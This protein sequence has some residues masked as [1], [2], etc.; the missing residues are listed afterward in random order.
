MRVVAGGE[1][2]DDTLPNRY[3]GLSSTKLTKLT[4]VWGATEGVEGPVWSVAL[5]SDGKLAVVSAPVGLEYED[6]S[7]ESKHL[8]QWMFT[9]HDVAKGKV[10]RAFSGHSSY[11]FAV[12]FSPDGKQILSG[13]EDGT[14]RLW[15]ISTGKELRT[16]EGHKGRVTGVAFSP[17]G[18]QG[19]SGGQDG[20]L[21]LWDLGTSKRLRTCTGHETGVTS[22]AFSHDGKTALSSG[23]DRTLRLWDLSTGKAI[24]TFEG[25]NGPVLFG[26]LL[27][28]WEACP[29]G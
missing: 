14:V 1:R 27:A 21:I 3:G 17:D 15:D 8:R 23:I 6:T 11:V 10:I 2:R 25:S 29:V 12:A 18:K 22:V 24:R 7:G 26:R 9:L 5:S 4:A 19:L 20:N 16:F 28:G 13:S